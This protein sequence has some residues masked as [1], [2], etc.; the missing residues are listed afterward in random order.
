MSM[1]SDIVRPFFTS[2]VEQLTADKEFED[3]S[4]M[5]DYLMDNKMVCQLVSTVTV[6]IACTLK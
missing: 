1:H 5:S 2:P 6:I 3:E 4:V